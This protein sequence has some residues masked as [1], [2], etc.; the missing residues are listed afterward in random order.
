MFNEIRKCLD[1]YE[2]V[3]EQMNWRNLTEEEANVLDYF[4]L[5]LAEA[6]MKDFDYGD[7]GEKLAKIILATLGMSNEIKVKIE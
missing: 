2:E 3:C 6:I 7:R 1:E 5:H 4:D